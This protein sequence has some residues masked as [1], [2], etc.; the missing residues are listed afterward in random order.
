MISKSR[1]SNKAPMLV[2]ILA[3]LFS[4]LV[5][6]ESNVEE[7][8]HDPQFAPIEEQY[9]MFPMTEHDFENWNSLGTAVFH[10]NMAVLV[11]EIPNA[12]GMVVTK[13]TN[14]KPDHWY[15]IVDYD[16]DSAPSVN[17]KFKR[18]VKLDVYYLRSFDVYDPDIDI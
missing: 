9:L 17:S 14:P 6:A 18:Q 1:V 12:A 7:T 4:T 5:Q 11:P 2:F 13:N 3:T 16:I 8:S 15:A 10:Q